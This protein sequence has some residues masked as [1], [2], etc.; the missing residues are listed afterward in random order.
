MF[1]NDPLATINSI[2]D[3]NSN[4]RISTNIFSNK[5]YPSAN[6]D[7][8]R[9]LSL[10]IEPLSPIYAPDF[11]PDIHSALARPGNAIAG[12][13]QSVL[14][15]KSFIKGEVLLVRRP[16][17]SSAVT[18]WDLPAC[19]SHTVWA[20]KPDDIGRLCY[21]YSVLPGSFPVNGGDLKPLY[22]AKFGKM[23]LPTYKD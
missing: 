6:E 13:V 18:A 21:D 8:K 22:K 7:L 3:Q 10:L 1:V 11:K 4:L 14:I 16:A 2:A 5:Y 20:Y 15:W 9:R 12:P 23:I 19:D 17:F